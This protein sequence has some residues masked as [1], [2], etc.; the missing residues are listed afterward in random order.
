[1][2]GGAGTPSRRKSRSTYDRATRLTTGKER[3]PPWIDPL[4][5]LFILSLPTLNLCRLIYL[6]VSA[7]M[8]RQRYFLREGHGLR[9]IT[10]H[11][12]KSQTATAICALNKE[13]S[14]SWLDDRHN[15]RSWVWLAPSRI[16]NGGTGCESGPAYS[17]NVHRTVLGLPIL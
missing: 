3:L 5:S 2:T 8:A 10:R 11:H 17:G 14:L 6:C 1:M 4:T 7:Y 16:A 12:L 15:L 13:I 9:W